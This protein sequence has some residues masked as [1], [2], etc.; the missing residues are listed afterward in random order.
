VF[1]KPGGATS[2][3]GASSN[4][5]PVAGANR[6]RPSQPD[7]ATSKPVVR[8]PI[9]TD[10]PG[11]APRR[12]QPTADRPASKPLLGERYGT[13]PATTKPPI[14]DKPLGGGKPVV[15][16]QPAVRPKPLARPAS[17]PADTVTTYAPR[18]GALRPTSA[19]RV[20]NRTAFHSNDGRYTQGGR[21]YGTA[22][23][24]YRD[25]CHRAV[26]CNYWNP[27]PRTCWW[28]GPSWSFGWYGGGCFSWSVSLWYPYWYC[29]S[30]YWNS[31]YYDAFWCGWSRP[32]YP[33]SCYW[34]YPSTVY[35]PTYLYVPSTVYVTQTAVEAPAEGT[36]APTIMTAGGVSD[37][38]VVRHEGAGAEAT[39]RS[40]AQK[41]VEL[42]DF[43]FRDN[44]F[45][46]AAEAYGKARAQVPDDASVHL[47][48]ADAVFADGDYHYAAFLVGE[49][50]R[51]DPAIAS[52]A[53]DK[54]TFYGDAKVF[55]AQ[56]Q[57]LDAYLERAPF[58]AQAHFVKG[59]NLRFSARRDEAKNSFQRV[60]EIEP[61]HRGAEAFLTAPEPAS[62][63]PAAT[64]AEAPT[65]IR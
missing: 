24:Y 42:G 45:R 51:L 65:E 17:R 55:D 14:A 8:E 30:A 47:V 61:G 62:A 7:T 20:P 28:G 53:T 41:Y 31:C 12:P 43:Y 18:L 27:W 48:L 26:W 44:R 10:K 36:P 52:A 4:R 60:F 59:Y 39:N 32:Y 13:R 57:A 58:D 50:L 64:P 33:A 37:R 46:D 54:R 56:M 34:W 19:T 22:G 21:I 2:N 16:D 38:V 3:S 63:A 35:C 49:A 11:L 23:S 40:M 29:R 9:A 1:A 6:Y 15:S 25:D 5:L